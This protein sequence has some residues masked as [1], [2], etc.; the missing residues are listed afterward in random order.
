LDK[1]KEY[2]IG[3]ISDTH[4]LLRP[5][6]VAAFA[7]VNLILHAG[8][9]GDPDII[10]D[11]EALAPLI[12]VRGNMDYGNWAERLPP[13]QSIQVGIHAILLIH[14]LGWI[15][16]DVDLTKYQAVIN[17]HTHRPLIEKQH[18]LLHFN[19]GSAGHRRSQYP[20]SIGK[21]LIRDGQLIPN[22]IDLK[23]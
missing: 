17:G 21:L 3:V 6:V 4:G 18:N 2:T 22:L 7:D 15:D 11:L 12:A 1:H 9:V 14:D 20:I 5:E 8:D 10:S 16:R 19:P 23:R 13:V